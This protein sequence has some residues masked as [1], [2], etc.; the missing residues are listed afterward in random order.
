MT[1]T[2]L[3]LILTLVFSSATRAEVNIVTTIKPL[4]LIA[5]AVIQG[6]GNVSAIMDPRQSPHH[7]SMSPSDRIAL[8]QA[9]IAIWIGP[10]FE[11][12][13]YDFF[14]Q[15]NMAEKTLTL[16]EMPNL[17]LHSIST[18]QLD[19]HL[20]LDSSNAV[21]IAAMIADRASKLDPRNE[22][23]YKQNLNRFAADIE[24]MNLQLQQKL[25]IQPRANYA[26]YHNAYQYFEKQ[27]GLQHALTILQ[28]P[29]TQPGIRQ[30][31][32]LRE[33]VQEQQPACLLLEIDASEDLVNTVLNGHQL[34]WI[35]VDLLAY[36]V[37][38][39]QDA[40]MQFMSNLGNDFVRCLYE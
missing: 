32:Q 9:D 6:H 3:S 37:P 28:D 14:S 11:S 39:G 13:L 2:I 21:K 26:V 33:Q 31:V 17:L 8:A 1:K 34:Q 36:R 30:I 7:F 24:K 12:F 10:G 38:S 40:Y 27:F 35:S 22:T 29:E 4:Q 25:S 20:W 23:A 16:I 15:K 5:Q 19:A 18:N